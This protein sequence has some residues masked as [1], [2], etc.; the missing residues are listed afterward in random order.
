[1]VWPFNRKKKEEPAPAADTSISLDEAAP[2]QEVGGAQEQFQDS[3]NFRTPADMIPDQPY[4]GAGP[5]AAERVAPPQ[6]GYNPYEGLPST[7][8]AGM[9]NKLYNLPESPEYLFD[10]EASYKRRA[11]NENLQYFT[12]LGYFGGSLAGG[13]YGAFKG[14]TTPAPLGAID[15][16][17]LKMNRVLN[18]A[19]NRGTFLGNSLGVVGLLYAV[20]DSAIS[21]ARGLDES[22]LLNST[23]AGVVTGMVYKSMSG[24]RAALVYGSAGGAIALGVNVA[25]SV[26]GLFS[27]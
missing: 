25:A 22:D 26:T 9:L 2:A 11:W 21:N 10:E 24:P 8:D 27:R 4:P 7:L 16:S 13:G 14:V 18:G 23:A 6:I 17:K 12:G 19:T 1:M 5:S 15:T 3:G 20:S